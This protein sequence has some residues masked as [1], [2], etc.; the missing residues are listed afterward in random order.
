MPAL[1]LAHSL[2]RFQIPRVI[3]EPINAFIQILSSYFGCQIPRVGE[4]LR[5]TSGL[6]RVLDV[7]DELSPSIFVQDKHDDFDILSKIIPQHVYIYI[8]RSYSTILVTVTFSNTK[9]MIGQNLRRSFTMIGHF[10]GLS[11]ETHTNTHTNAPPCQTYGIHVLASIRFK[12]CIEL[13]ESAI[14]KSVEMN[15][16]N[17]NFRSSVF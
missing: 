11:L 1:P 8:Y 10:K 5:C 13:S 16:S 7:F 4:R 14:K 9:A 2:G 6:A 15:F 12:L 3:G 17:L